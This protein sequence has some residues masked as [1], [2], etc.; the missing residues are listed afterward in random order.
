L[1]LPPSE[2]SDLALTVASD[3]DSSDTCPQNVTAQA[4]EVS[5]PCKNTADTSDTC[6]EQ[7]AQS[8]FDTADTCEKTADTADTCDCLTLLEPISMMQIE[9][10]GGDISAFIGCRV[11][12]RSLSGDVAFKG[13]MIRWDA[14]HGNI[15]VLTALGERIAHVRECFL[16]G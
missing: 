2:K 8:P 6:P 16:I 1:D 5:D 10:D 7:L 9:I 13:E 4:L 3:S 12:K 14:T 11:E 15:A